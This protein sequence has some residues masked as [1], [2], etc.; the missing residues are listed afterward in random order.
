VAVPAS[1]IVNVYNAAG[2]VDVLAD[3]VGYYTTDA[4]GEGGRYVPLSPNR[5]TDTRTG[6]TGPWG[7]VHPWVQYA[8]VIAGQGGIPA[9]GA[10]AAVM[11]VTVTEP[12]APGWITVHPD[13]V[14]DTVP[15]AS[16]LNFRAG[17]T[18]ANMVIGKLATED[19]C[20]L[21]PGASYLRNGSPGYVHLLIDVSG[22]FTADS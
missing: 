13:E 12:T 9:A 21:V 1:G 19:A 5:V 4:P 22:Y 11:N 16:S 10:A 20:D 18:A 6:G 3:V 8:E 7:R 17:D 15:E 14:C 2:S